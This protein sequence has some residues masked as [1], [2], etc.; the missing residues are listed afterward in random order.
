MERNIKKYIE[1]IFGMMLIAF[2]F[3]LFIYPL[4]IVIGGT[5]GIAVLVNEITSLDTS[6]FVTLFYIATFILNLIVFGIKDTKKLILGSVL[7][8]IF[9]KLFANVTTYIPLDYTNKLLIYLVASITIGVGNGLVYKEGFITGG[10]DV[11]KKIMNQKLKMPMGTCVFIMDALIVL[12]GGYIFGINS[13]LYAII[14]LFISSKATDMMM[15]GV[16]TKKMF[17]IMTKSPNEVRKYVKDNL[18]C[19]ITEIDAIGGY[20]EDKYHVL[21][22]V[23]STKD[24]MKLKKGINAIDENAFFVVTDSYHMHYHEEG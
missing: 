12:S 14:I 6:L 19:G 20:T 10:T 11:I 7:Y 17:Y 16:S 3:N 8:P 4:K 1:I 21:M 24:Y 23:I 18:N 15:L 9:V 13:V 22:C 2:S 5:N